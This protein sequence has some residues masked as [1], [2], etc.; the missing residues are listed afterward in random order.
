MIGRYERLRLAGYFSE[1]VKEKL[2]QEG[3][4]FRLV[5][6]ADGVWQLVPTDY[7][8][9]K[10]TG[11]DDS[12]DTWTV[13]NRFA[14]QPVK[15]RI[16]ALYSVEP[17]D[18]A[19]SLVLADFGKEDEFTDRA[20]ASGITHSLSS[21]TE[22]VKVG[23]ASGRYSAT[24]T[25]KSRQGAWAKAAKIFTPT[26][27]IDKYDALGVWIH[28]DGKGELLNLQ[29]TTPPQYY[30][31][32]DEHYVKVDFQGWRYF[33]LLLRERD[34]EKFG[35]YVWPYR[36]HY[37]VYRAPLQRKHLSGLNLYFNNLPPEDSVACYLSPIKALRTK[38]VKLR[39]PSIEV[40]SQ[41]IVFPVTLESGCYI[42]FNSMSDCKLYDERGAMVQQVQPQGEVPDL[43]GGKNE[44]KFTCGSTQHYNPRATVTLITHGKPLQE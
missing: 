41:R 31:A 14:A 28:G 23:Q 8:L 36:G 17:Y 27:D 35:D 13:K 4:E 38:K 33:E 43:A 15:L 21:S 9:H 39:N 18:S 29:L 24:S 11:L 5:Q 42:E 22:Q 6:V 37:S 30:R 16:E 19:E 12:T 26:V 40:A 10:V 3:D 44:V 25:T 32:W 7:A 2:R 20:A 1:S 34:A